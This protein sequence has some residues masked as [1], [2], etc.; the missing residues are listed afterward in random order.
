MSENF[1]REYRTEM[2][3]ENDAP[4]TNIVWEH[5]LKNLSLVERMTFLTLICLVTAIALIGNI[6]TIYVVLTRK[7]RLLFKTCLL[8][9][10]ISDLL[11]VLASGTSFISKLSREN[12]PLWVSV[13]VRIYEH[14]VNNLVMFL[15]TLGSFGCTA[16]PFAQTLSVLV[17]SMSL[18]I[19]AFDRYLAVMNKSEARILQKRTTCIIGFCVV[20]FIGC[21]TSS[22]TL[23]AYEIVPTIVVPFYHQDDF[24][25][26]YYCWTDIDESANY[27]IIVFTFI[28]APIFIAF[29]WLNTIIAREIWKR[30]HAPGFQSQPKS[31]KADENSS[32]EEMKATDETNTSSNVRKNSTKIST[33]ESKNSAVSSKPS[34]FIIQPPSTPVNNETR[35]NERQRR[36]MR[37]FK[38]VLVLMSVFIMCRLPNQ[39]FLLYKLNN[40]I[41]GRLNWLLYYSFGLTGLLNCMLNPMLYTFL[42]ETI[43][44]TSHVASFCYKFCK[45]CR[46][47]KK[48]SSHYANNQT[49]LFAV[50]IPRKSDGGIYLGS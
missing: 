42:S 15:K 31:K 19:I 22:P 34:P 1:N 36:Q 47:T 4:Q 17:G 44:I 45:I 21:A 39:I 6:L 16:I 35:R 28:F 33:K 10:T 11:Y 13:E 12:L 29:L 14:K 46:R 50:N 41:D 8:S 9:L 5:L 27:Y 38:A 40:E 3:I 30:R 18:V 26:A 2:Q 48:T 24:F 43:R 20:W 37:M 32:T 25:E 49:M 7:Q 23:F